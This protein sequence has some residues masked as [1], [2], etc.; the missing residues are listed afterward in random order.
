MDD[1]TTMCYYG[2]QDDAA[3]TRVVID[4]IF[5]HEYFTFQFER[6]CNVASFVNAIGTFF[7]YAIVVSSVTMLTVAV[8][9]R[10]DV[11][12]LVDSYYRR[13]FVCEC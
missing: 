8:M 9:M 6:V 5:S 7:C 4:R 11:S 3:Q 1:G 2:Y 12:C 13:C 10:V